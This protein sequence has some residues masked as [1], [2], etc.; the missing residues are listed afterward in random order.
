MFHTNGYFYGP[1][2]DLVLWQN[3]ELCWQGKYGKKKAAY[4]KYRKPFRENTLQLERREPVNLQKHSWNSQESIRSLYF[5]KRYRIFCSK[6]HISE[7]FANCRHPCRS[8]SKWWVPSW[9]TF[10]DRRQEGDASLLHSIR[11]W[12]QGPDNRK[13]YV[14][15]VKRGNNNN[16][17][18]PRERDGTHRHWEAYRLPDPPWSIGWSTCST[19]GYTSITDDLLL[20]SLGPWP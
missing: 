14:N 20:H 17:D 15:Q 6:L 7:I 11:R 13:Y 8:L 16:F 3:F 2:C 10:N 12:T 5:S 4:F 1:Y 18:E 19:P 9:P